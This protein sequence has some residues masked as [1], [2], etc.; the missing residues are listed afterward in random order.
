MCD[1]ILYRIE[2]QTCKR[3]PWNCTCDRKW[4]LIDGPL[5]PARTIT[6]AGDCAW[7]DF[8]DWHNDLICGFCDTQVPPE[9]FEIEL[10]EGYVLQKFQGPHIHSTSN[11]QSAFR[12]EEVSCAL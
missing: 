10:P 1:K 5:L 6:G 8:P 3:G 4:S 2:C 11:W 9:I 12:R 7:Q